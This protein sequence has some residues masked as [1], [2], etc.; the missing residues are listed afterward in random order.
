[1]I[2]LEIV[3]SLIE[4]TT[5]PQNRFAVLLPL[6]N[7][8][9]FFYLFIISV[10]ITLVMPYYEI[11]LNAA[12]PAIYGR[13]SVPASRYVLSVGSICAL[14]GAL[15]SSLLPP[16]RY[17]YSMSVDGLLCG[18][19]SKFTSKL[20]TMPLVSF[21]ISLTLTTLCLLFD[22][23][24]LLS[25]LRILLPARFIVLTA[26]TLMQRYRDTPAG[27]LAEVANYK[28]VSPAK[29]GKW[30]EIQK[31]IF[32]YSSKANRFH[33][34]LVGLGRVWALHQRR[35]V[36]VYTMGADHRSIAGTPLIDT[37]SVRR[38]SCATSRRPNT[39]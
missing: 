35:K 27:L 3:G 34:S 5:N 22:S 37:V 32:R 20:G 17:L 6:M 8:L 1:M 18:V 28:A 26:A 30:R 25:V 9:L 36:A 14:S 19:C 13:I 2:G 29:T 24:T 33:H 10:I 4:E 15:L 12:L 7:T 21:A 39:T 31:M 23:T 16:I 11:P 38:L